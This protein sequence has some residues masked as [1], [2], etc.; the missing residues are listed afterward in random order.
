ML[1]MENF[2]V[3]IGKRIK[4]A[5]IESDTPQEALAEMLG[6]S[7][8]T[9]SA[10]ESG[11]NQITAAKLNEIAVYL[12]KPISYFFAP[13]ESS[14]SASGLSQTQTAARTHKP[15]LKKANGGKRSAA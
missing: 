6:V 15:P 10:W 8:Q 9:V 11:R 1:M 2:K 4:I 12:H 7:P 5:R 3:D 14:L 13:F